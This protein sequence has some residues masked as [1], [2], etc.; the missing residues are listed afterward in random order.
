MDSLYSE[1]MAEGG[2]ALVSMTG[3]ETNICCYGLGGSV[4]Q[5]VAFR[6]GL[7]MGPTE[8]SASGKLGERFP[9]LL[10]LEKIE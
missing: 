4:L 1:R 2:S 5:F 8:L 6:A 9:H 7:S 3:L 10:A